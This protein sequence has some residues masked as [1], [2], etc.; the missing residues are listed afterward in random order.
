MD[1]NH[2]SHRV[3]RKALVRAIA[4]GTN[5]AFKDVLV[6]FG[7]GGLAASVASHFVFRFI[8]KPMLKHFLKHGAISGWKDHENKFYKQEDYVQV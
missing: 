3:K 6:H 7:V 2:P 8:F 5:I 1:S 4:E